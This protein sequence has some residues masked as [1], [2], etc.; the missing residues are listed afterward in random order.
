[1]S[2]FV[3]TNVFLRFLVRDDLEKSARSGELLVRADRGAITL[4]TSEAVVLEAVQVLSR[5]Y[6]MERSMIATV[7][8]SLLENRGLRVD[9]KSTLIDAF[10]LYQMTNLDYTDCLGA[11]YARRTSEGVVYSYDRGLD[12]VP[13]IRRLEP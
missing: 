9:H 10:D 1:M 2:D 12:R 11:E 4:M 6:R 5:L 7:L 8:Q 13:G 3:D